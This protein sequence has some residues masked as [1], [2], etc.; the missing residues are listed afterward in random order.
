[1][2]EK[3]NKAGRESDL[4]T[5]IVFLRKQ[6]D[7]YKDKI[8]SVDSEIANI[9]IELSAEASKM[10]EQEKELIKQVSGEAAQQATSLRESQKSIKYDEMLADLNLQLLEAKKKRSVLQK[11]F[12]GGASVNAL[13]ALS[14]QDFDND[15]HIREYSKDIADKELSIAKLLSEGY[16]PAHPVVRKLQR[17]TDTIKSLRAKRI[18]D[19]RS[20]VES[21]APTEAGE[22]DPIKTDI[23]DL[24]WQI[25]TLK[26]KIKLIESYQKNAE[27]KLNTSELKASAVSG[28]ISR[29]MELR[30]EKEINTGY[31]SG[32]RKQLEEADLKGRIEKE[33]VGINIRIVEAPKIP[34]RPIPF[35]KMPKLLMGLFMAF[36]A[37]AGLAYVADALDQS[38]KTSSDLRELLKVPVLASTDR[39]NTPGDIMLKRLRRNG[40]L[41]G[42]FGSAILLHIG[43]RFLLTFGRGG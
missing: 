24:E 33:Q 2:I 41:V 1:L 10:T 40:L 37:G 4:E 21:R 36:S 31:Y 13:D 22:K 28:K 32:V 5:G 11:R 6:L 34:I 9:K 15:I 27:E 43:V 8:S 12:K 42:L 17:E 30:S 3:E 16:M 38:I 23:E 20:G 7:F 18:E 19:L 14:E 26:D 29:L 35:Q 39:I 25:G